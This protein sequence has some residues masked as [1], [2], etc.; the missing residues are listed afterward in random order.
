MKTSY[1]ATFSN[2]TVRKIAKST[3]EYGF[4]YVWRGRDAYGNETGGSGFARTYELA[5][6]AMATEQSFIVTVPKMHYRGMKSPA[7]VAYMKKIIAEWKP[8]T[9]TFTEIVSV[10]KEA[11]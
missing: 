3:R 6:K 1:T 4:A 10:E 2:G 5:R 9:V 7:Y 11:A 8:G